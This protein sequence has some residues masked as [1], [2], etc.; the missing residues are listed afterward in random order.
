MSTRLPTPRAD[1]PA[2]LQ[3]LARVGLLQGL[4]AELLTELAQAC[5]LRR[6]RARQ[7]V[8]SRD[9]VDRDCCL[10]L[11]GR[12]RVTAWTPQGREISWRELQ[13]GEIFGELAA[14]DGLPR[15]AS[16]VALSE[17]LLARLDPETLRALMQRHWPMAER[18]LQH[19]AQSARVLTERLYRLGAQ[20]VQQRL[21][22]ELLRLSAPAPGAATMPRVLDPAPSQRELAARIDTVR[23]QVLRELAALERAGLIRRA[24]ARIELP[25]VPRLAALIDAEAAC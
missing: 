22:A 25:D 23:E 5:Q 16:V 14:I 9:D 3:A 4:K 15:S 24:G 20:S 21:A 7:E 2:V 18:L 10:I 11:Q 8:L 6:Y 1:D 12:L 19:L 13:A 17:V